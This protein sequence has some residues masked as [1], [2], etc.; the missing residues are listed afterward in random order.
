MTSAD[1]RARALAFAPHASAPDGGFWARVAKMKLSETMLRESGI[2]CACRVRAANR[3]EISGAHALDHE[4]FDGLNASDGGDGGGGW[5]ARGDARLLNTR[6]GVTTFDREAY[7][8]EIGEEILR[9][10]ESGDAERDPS[11]LMR[12]GM[13]AYACLKSWSF[14]YWFAFPAATSAEFTI[15]S[16]SVEK[17]RA[18]DEGDA[19]RAQA[20]DNWIASGG[21]FAWLLDEDGASARPLADYS[22]IV[23]EGRRPTLAFADTCGS[24][25]HP[26][27]ALRNLAVLASAS[28]EAS[29]LDVV[30]VR[31]RKG[32]VVPEACV[33]FTMFLP[34]FDK[35]AVKFVGWERNTRGKMGP[36][37]VDLGT[38]MDPTQ[39][40]SQAV[41]LNLK[42]M[43]WRLLPELDQDKLASTKCLLIGAGTLGCAVARTLMGWGVRHITLLDSGRVSYSNPVRQTLFEFK[44]CFDG[45]APKAEA[46]ANKLADIF[47]GVNSRGIT[48]S[49]PMPGHSVSNDL[50]ESVFRDIDA[51]ETLIDEHDAVYVLTDTRESRWLPTVI[52]AS[53]DK[54]CINTALGF[55]TYVVMRHGCGVDADSDESRLGCYFCNDVMAPANSTRDRTLDQQCTVTRPGLAPIASALAVELMVAL[56]HTKD[57]SKTA[58]PTRN[59]DDSEPSPLGVVPHQIRGSVA[60]FTQTMFDA[61]AFP[62]CTACS[63]AIVNRYRADREGFLISVFDDPKTLEDATGLTELLGAVDADDAEWLDDDDDF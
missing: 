11:R 40:A 21:A 9:D 42:L 37:T 46:A 41:D 5:V 44:D 24:A 36:R 6:E 4:S 17:M 45:G 34:K 2:S 60:G 63:R 35:D 61:P 3:A 50:K 28:W 39:L 27:W 13:I 43:R 8:R 62:R 7:L 47:P 58:P 51:L 22:N 52:C 49:I 56:L 14:T 55:N 1:A 10:I 30:C 48:M 31:T 33:K 57:G 15:T 59:A 38:S 29:E 12:F 23:A 53:K 26:G 54:L 32:R 16:T 19:M 25:T 20:C 18:E